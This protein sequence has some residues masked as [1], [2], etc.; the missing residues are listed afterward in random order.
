MAYQPHPTAGRGPYIIAHRGLSAKAP[1]NTLAAFSRAAG[2]DGI[3]LVE[4]DV[5]LSRDEEVIVLHDRTLQRTSTGNGPARNYRLA[6]IQAFDA[7]SWFHPSFS[8]ERIP[9]LQ[10]VLSSVGDRVMVNIEIKSDWLH[11]EPKGLLEDRVM[12]VVRACGMVDR[13]LVS[14]FDHRL[15]ANLK[16]RSPEARTGI[17]YNLYRDFGR[18][19][20]ALAAHTGAEV[21]VCARH[22]LRPALVR[23]A[24]EHGLAV[25]VY[26]LDAPSD[27][28]SV[29]ALGVDGIL[30]NGADE[31]VPL[32]AESRPR[33]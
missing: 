17:L 29:L 4:L 5:R 23:D 25:Y 19:P 8:G 31:V 33:P 14:S 1:E 22:E 30:S 2:T 28:R 13:V 15:I 7:G 16:Q 10:A 11:R 18:R 26:T 27:V 6:E 12:N 3:D 21:F 20:S 24:H 32:V 9:T